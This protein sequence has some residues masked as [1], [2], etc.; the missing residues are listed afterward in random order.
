MPILP[1]DDWWGKAMAQYWFRLQRNGSGSLTPISW[2]G[3]AITIGMPL[4]LVAT[5]IVLSIVVDTVWL[6]VAIGLP[7]AVLVVFVMVRVAR[8]KTEGNLRWQTGRW[9]RNE[10]I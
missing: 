10:Q 7:I 6:A 9:E 5:I 1:D 4:A 3:W 8:R 2:Q